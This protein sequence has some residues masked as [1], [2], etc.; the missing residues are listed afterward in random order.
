M[1]VPSGV[2][3]PASVLASLVEV[4]ADALQGRRFPDPLVAEALAEAVRVGR[5]ARALTAGV[6]GSVNASTKWSAPP[7]QW[8]VPE[9]AQAI[10]RKPGTVRH[11]ARV[12]N[13]I[14]YPDKGGRWTFEDD[15]VKRFIER[16]A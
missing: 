7:R 6:D 1:I 4:L 5:R 11:H 12:G 9:V 15:A 2:L 14:G 16:T 3:L 8:S 13:L 10:G